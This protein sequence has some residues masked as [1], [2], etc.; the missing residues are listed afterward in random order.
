[1]N[2]HR[3]RPARKVLTTV[4][5]GMP[6]ALA[7]TMTHAQMTFFEKPPSAQ[8][9]R[10]ALMGGSTTQRSAA[11]ASQKVIRPSG[12][13]VR[14]IVW[15][16]PKAGV[17]SNT[18]KQP[19]IASQSAQQPLPSAAPSAGMP[20][21]FELGSARPLPGSIG[22]VRSVAQVMQQDPNVRLIIEG[23]TDASGSYKRNMV[24]SWDRAMGVFR[25]LAIVA[26][27]FESPANSSS[28]GKKSAVSA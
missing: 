24:L 5:V 15:D 13:K 8:E 17:P 9:L 12:V 20:I 23:H 21:N 27:S 18:P 3:N 2:S 26:C 11:P 28:L 14:G 19:T 22:F 7:A 4:L 10:Q 6:L 1:M 25:V 16:K